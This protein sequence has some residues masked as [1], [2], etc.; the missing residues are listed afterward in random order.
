MSD[1][2][3]QDLPAPRPEIA[4]GG[5]TRPDWTT[6]PERDPGLLWLDK[7]ENGDPEM[8]ALVSRHLAGLGDEVGSSYPELTSLYH[9][10]GAFVGVDPGMLVVTGGADGG[11]RSVFDAYVGQGDVVLRV[12]P[13]YAMYDVYGR[14]YGA[15]QVV[16]D[17]R[18]SESGPRLDLDEVLTLIADWTPRLVCLPN[19]A[20]PTGGVLPVSDLAR[21]AQATSAAG[22]ILLVDEAYHP[23]DPVTAVPLIDDNPNVIVVRTFSK[24]WGMSGLR[25]GYCVADHRVTRFLHKVRPGYESN[26]AAVRVA[27]RLLGEEA[28][29]W[30]SVHRL[31]DGRDRFCEAMVDLGLRV[32]PS[33]GNFLLVAFAEHAEA[34][35]AALDD[36]VLYRRDFGHPSLAGF[37]RFSATTS[38]RF[39][40]VVRRIRAAVTG[41]GTFGSSGAG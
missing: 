6:P 8:W 31:N 11:I 24:A 33:G 22:G 20:S 7:N 23:F 36:L 15:D 5:L 26:F 25:I 9:R 17:H 3:Q 12:E 4:D 1:P 16:V 21:I 27:E 32:A 34:V 29:M 35:H 37:S 41:V 14:M 19:P 30:R 28:S 39:E 38:E 13:T 10:L 18:P 2:G 40:P